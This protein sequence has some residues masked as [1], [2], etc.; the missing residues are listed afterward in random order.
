MYKSKFIDLQF[1]CFV[2]VKQYCFIVNL[3]DSI[4]DFM[5][6]VLVKLCNL[7][8]NIESN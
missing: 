4:I 3:N 2:N 7:N 8:Y 5:K 1:F 6:K